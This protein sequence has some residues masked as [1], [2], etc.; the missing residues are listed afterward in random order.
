KDP[1]LERGDWVWDSSFTGT[2]E[3]E[4][5]LADYSLEFYS[6]LAIIGIIAIV[7]IAIVLY[8]FLRRKSVRNT[9]VIKR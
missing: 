1:F 3:V 8:I 4:Q 5:L 6:A 2:Y 7:I 9:I